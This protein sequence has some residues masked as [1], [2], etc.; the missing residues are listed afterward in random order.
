M[1]KDWRVRGEGRGARRCTMSCY[2]V[3]IVSPRPYR[4]LPACHTRCGQKMKA[5]RGE[6]QVT[7]VD[8]RVQTAHPQSSTP[9]LPRIC[10]YTPSVACQDRDMAGSE[11]ST[12]ISLLFLR[13]N[14]DSSMRSPSM[15]V[16][17]CL[18]IS[19]SIYKGRAN[20]ERERRR[21]VTH[22]SRNRCLP[23]LKSLTP[24]PQQHQLFTA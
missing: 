4:N 18:T 24:L 9:S 19:G 17:S 3:G 2:P 5:E 15:S 20:F 8:R 21:L 6:E 16:W 14:P 7:D 10:V 12:A 23:V 1:T 22:P 11:S 13:D